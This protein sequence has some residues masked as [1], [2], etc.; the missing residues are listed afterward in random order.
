MGYS[1]F[2]RDCDADANEVMLRRTLFW[3]LIPDVN[4]KVTRM[5]FEPML[6]P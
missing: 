2:V 3:I 4:K 1:H 6:P 5:G